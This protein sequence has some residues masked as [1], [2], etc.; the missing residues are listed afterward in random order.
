MPDYLALDFPVLRE[1]TA[2]FK[3]GI[4]YT[5]TATRQDETLMVTH[6]LTGQSYIS[7]LIKDGK[8]KFSAQLFYKKSSERKHRFADSHSTNGLEITATQAIPL[9]FSYPPDVTGNIVIL[10]QEKITNDAESGLD[11]FWADVKKFTIPEF[12]RIAYHA[13]LSFSSDAL[14]QLI[15]LVC[16][17]T[18]APGKMQ[19]LVNETA[20]EGT[21]PVKLVCSQDVYDELKQATPEIQNNPKTDRHATRLAI[22]TQA[23]CATYA[24]MQNIKLPDE[25]INGSLL[26]H[27]EM[28]SEDWRGENFNPS[29][30]ATEIQPYILSKLQK[31]SSD[32]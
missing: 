14:Q 22:L 1:D 7:R 28:L 11:D 32:E 2:D 9:D 16:K 15:K 25:Q 29:L 3:G 21:C 30:A 10:S 8:A 5:V 17:E 12:A 24:H 4:A 31:E 19:T 18:L 13:K 23:L 26:K 20:D 27:L 6:T